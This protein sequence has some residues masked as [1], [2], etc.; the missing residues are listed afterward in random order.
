[1]MDQDYAVE[2]EAFCRANPR[3]CPLLGVIPGGQTAAPEFGRDIDLRTDLRSYD[4][5][6]D[7]RNIGSRSDVLGLYHPRLVSFLIGSSVS[8]D[9]LLVDKGFAPS[10][11]PCIYLT[12]VG[13][14]WLGNPG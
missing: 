2:F 11:G 3:P 4:A 9:G 13:H 1:M 6:V 8:F 5:L 14:S 10:Y 12:A 7:G